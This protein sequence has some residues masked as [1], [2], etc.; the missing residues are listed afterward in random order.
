MPKREDERYAAEKEN[1]IW[2]PHHK[3]YYDKRVGCQRCYSER[4]HLGGNVPEVKECPHCKRESVSWNEYARQF[5]CLNPRCKK[6]YSKEEYEAAISSHSDVKLKCP[7]CCQVSVHWV[8]YFACYQ[9]VKC[10]RAFS[11]DELAK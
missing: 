6:T 10:N 3:H 2:C 8:R 5:E 7:N 4:L 9:C 1:L 11:K